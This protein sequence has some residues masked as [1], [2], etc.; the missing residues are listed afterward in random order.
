MRLLV[1]L[2]ILLILKASHMCFLPGWIPNAVLWRSWFEWQSSAEDCNSFRKDNCSRSSEFQS[3]SIPI[4]CN[5][6]FP[7]PLPPRPSLFRLWNEARSACSRLFF[8]YFVF[9][10]RRTSIH[11]ESLLST[12]FSEGEACG[13]WLL[14]RGYGQCNVLSLT[15]NIVNFDEVNSSLFI[16]L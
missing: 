11:F 5:D 6:Y 2:M 7:P 9:E 8:L 14:Q 15:H 3:F 4:H 10:Q 12:S 13:I 1:S 16:I